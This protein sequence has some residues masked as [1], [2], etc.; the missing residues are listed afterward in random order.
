[1]TT[2]FVG[3]A[4]KRKED[5]RL[6]T[7][8][9]NYVDD[10]TP[11]GTLWMAFVRSSEAHARIASTDKSAAEERPDVVGVFTFEDLAV[12]GSSP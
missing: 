5:P 4:M 12:D 7:G 6:I 9:G 8:R 3:R 1:M 2:A 10:V 11:A